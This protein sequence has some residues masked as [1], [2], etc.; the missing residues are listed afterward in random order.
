MDLVWQ[1]N[2][3][4]GWHPCR[5][6]LGG[7]SGMN[8]LRCAFL[9]HIL[10]YYSPRAND[11][12]RKWQLTP[13]SLPGRPPWT[14]EPQVTVPEVP[15]SQTQLVNI[16]MGILSLLQGIFPTRWLNPELPHCRWILYQLSHKGSPR[17]LEWV[18][19][20]FSRGPSKP[21]N[22]TRSPELQVGSL[23]TEL[24][25]KPQNNNIKIIHHF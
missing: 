22:R 2:I 13:V 24:S 5:G 21:S 19:Y 14:E 7:S 25:E 3:T 9:S 16:E 23:P 11:C 12:R 17:I 4:Q 10:I 20:P 18:A 8:I 6:R 1:S 15:K